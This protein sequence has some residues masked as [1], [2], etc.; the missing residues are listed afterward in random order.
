MKILSL[1]EFSGIVYL[2]HMR[3][4]DPIP[5]ELLKNNEMGNIDP[6]SDTYYYNIYCAMY[7]MLSTHADGERTWEQ[8][9]KANWDALA[10]S[11]RDEKKAIAL[12]KKIIGEQATQTVGLENMFQS[13]SADYNKRANETAD[14][15][16]KQRFGEISDFYKSCFETLGLIYNRFF[17]Q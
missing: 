9:I 13:I 15:D 1:D 4:N 2:K 3:E 14:K 16:E 7:D 5:F 11:L 6:K 17:A 10:A 12:R 8:Q